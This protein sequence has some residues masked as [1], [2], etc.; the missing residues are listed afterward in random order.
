[1]Y[2]ITLETSRQKT[3]TKGKPIGFD[4]ENSAYSTVQ[5]NQI[6]TGDQNEL[7]L[8]LTNCQTGP[9]QLFGG[10]LPASAKSKPDLKSSPS[11]LFLD[12]GDV[13]KGTELSR[14]SVDKISVGGE[15][16]PFKDTG[17]KFKSFAD[18]FRLGLCPGSDMVI[19]AGQTVAFHFTG[20]SCT[21]Q[22]FTRH[23]LYIYYANMG[24]RFVAN[25]G[26]FSITPLLVSVPPKT[27]LAI[28]NN[29]TVSLSSADNSEPA[30]AWITSQPYLDANP[31]SWLPNE[32]ILKLA[33]TPQSRDG[34]LDLTGAEF[35]FSF[36]AGDDTVEGALTTP[37]QVNQISCDK[38]AN[39]SANPDNANPR[40]WK[41]TTGQPLKANSTA[42]FKFNNIHIGPKFVEGDAY[43][44]LLFR[45]LPG[46]QDGWFALRVVR[47]QAKLKLKPLTGPATEVPFGTAVKLSWSSFA[48]PY[49]GL[50]YTTVY[51]TGTSSLVNK[52]VPGEA[53]NEDQGKIGD[54]TRYILSGYNSKA[55]FDSNTPI[56]GLQQVAIVTVIHTAPTINSFT[57]SC[58]PDGG[59]FA[60]EYHFR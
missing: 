49:L 50:S 23:T 39:W 20:V 6:Y 54:E 45:S 9:L 13:F 30:K 28:G 5:P 10:E 12:F 25:L 40:Q 53:T 55:D 4:L 15:L 29:L 22:E 52:H 38:D 18:E 57:A 56:P 27:I 3:L 32:L 21:N 1:M 31:N 44:Y 41:F 36:V 59:D 14:M 60:M 46:F 26:T 8:K 2:A 48:I 35:L 47:S 11:T 33:Y 24:G 58:S 34:S 43:A 19:P 16:K 42:K 51:P 17:W 7:V 37:D